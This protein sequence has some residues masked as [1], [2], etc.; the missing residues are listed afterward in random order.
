MTEK[1]RWPWLVSLQAAI[2]VQTFLGMTMKAQTFYCGGSLSRTAGCSDQASDWRGGGRE[3]LGPGEGRGTK[4]G[5]LSFSISKLNIPGGCGSDFPVS[6]LTKRVIGGEVTE[7]GRWPWLVSPF[8]FA[9]LCQ[10]HALRGSV[11]IPISDGPL[12]RIYMYHALIGGEVT[13]KGPVAL[14]GV[15]PGSHP[16][17]DFP[18][19]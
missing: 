3:F 5:T 16:C 15:A 6:D 19:V 2:P 11:G 7:K 14:A 10:Q 17:A 9:S 12:G 1:G 13:E 4:A 8:Y 18:G